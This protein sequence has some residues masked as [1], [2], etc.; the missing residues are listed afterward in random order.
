MVMDKIKNYNNTH[1]LA[2]YV[3]YICVQWLPYTETMLSK[4]AINDTVLLY[5]QI[6]KMS[7]SQVI[8]ML[9]QLQLI[10]FQLPQLK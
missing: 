9:K 8:T 6:Q 3:T 4:F 1:M 10:Y 5:R 2:I 7:T